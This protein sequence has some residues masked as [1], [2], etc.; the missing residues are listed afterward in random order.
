MDNLVEFILSH[1]RALGSTRSWGW[2]TSSCREEDFIWSSHARSWGWRTAYREE[3]RYVD[4]I[5]SHTIYVKIGNFCLLA[6][7]W[8]IQKWPSIISCCC[9][10]IHSKSKK[11]KMTT[12]FEYFLLL[13]YF[14]LF[15]RSM[16]SR[17]RV[18]W[19]VNLIL[20]HLIL[21]SF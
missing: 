5:R 18:H 19:Y 2:G 9:C 14:I 8:K 15:Y 1:H 10:K 12:V 11:N 6:I 21:S 4:F 13:A 16:R 17:S 3:R 20:L 7:M